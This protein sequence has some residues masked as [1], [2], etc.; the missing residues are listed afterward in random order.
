MTIHQEREYSFQF[1]SGGVV[2]LKGHIYIGFYETLE[3]DLTR[4]FGG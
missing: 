1:R 2:V 3:Q 4:V